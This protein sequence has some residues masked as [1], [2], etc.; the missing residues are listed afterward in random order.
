MSA[1]LSFDQTVFAVTPILLARAADRGL[2]ARRSAVEATEREIPYRVVE[3][4][5]SSAGLD[6]LV[7]AAER[8]M[9]LADQRIAFLETRRKQGADAELPML[10]AQAE[11][12]RG[13]QD[14]TRGRNGK[15][16]LLEVLGMLLGEAPP[17]ALTQPPSRL[18][19]TDPACCYRACKNRRKHLIFH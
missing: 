4:Y 15:R 17:A 16:Q 19:W 13:Q 12:A 14:L 7:A 8:A 11:K 1:V 3:V 9:A 10:R 18:T 2:T 5:Y 6:R